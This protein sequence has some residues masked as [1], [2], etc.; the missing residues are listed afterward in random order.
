[1][2]SYDK[3]GIWQQ[4]LA[5]RVDDPYTKERERLRAAYESVRAR[6]QP[7]AEAIAKD[8]PD[9]T[10]H[11]IT[12]SDA[13]WEYA[14]LIAGPAYP[15]NPCEAFVLGCAFLVHDLGMGLAAHP[16]GRAGLRK[17][18][19]WKDTVA[20]LLRSKGATA[21]D[22]VAIEHAEVEIQEHALVEVLRRLHAQ[23]ADKLMLIQWQ[24]PSGDQQ[25]HLIEDPELRDSFGSIIGRI[26]A[27]HWTAADQLLIDFPTVMGAQVG[28]PSSWTIDPLKFSCLLRAA[29]YSH[30]DERRAPAFLRA[31]RCP[32]GTSDDHWKFQGKLYQ[33][34]LDGDRLIFT[35]K[36]GFGIEDSSAWWVCFDTLNSIDSELRK[37]DSLL[38]DTQRM[39]LAARGVSQTDEPSRLAKLIGTDGWRPVDTRIRVSAVADLVRK[40]GGKDLYGDTEVPPLREMIQ[41]AADAV[42]ARRMIDGHAASWGEIRVTTGKSH[43]GAWIQVE[44]TGVGMSEAVLTGPLLDFGMSFWGT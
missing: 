37:V 13:L 40:L 30:I 24:S 19:L 15:L 43:L 42:R 10:V 18:V 16:E 44:D 5:A 35:A 4:A 21:I 31:L 3:T 33:P 39:R 20:D 11:D 26:S 23:R 27:S 1:M 14:D 17:L 2:S 29:D 8:L 32:H 12:H 28:F 25:F 9:F 38:A 22:D 7:L 6:A 34:R 36:S 41:N